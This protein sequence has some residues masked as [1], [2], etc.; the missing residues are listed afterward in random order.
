VHRALKSHLCRCTGWTP[1]LDAAQ[2]MAAG[3]PVDLAPLSSPR[4]QQ[5]AQ[6]EGR[7]AQTLGPEVALGGGGFA[8]DTAPRTAL[9][10]IAPEQLAQS[11]ELTQPRHWR[12][13]ADLTT[14][15]S[16][17]GSI[18]GRRSSLGLTWPIEHRDVSGRVLRELQTTWV[19]PAYL[20]PD[21]SWC[22]PGGEPAPTHANGGA[23]GGK[24]D[25]ALPDLV[26]ALSLEHDVPVRAQLT[27][28]Q[29]VQWGPKRPPMAIRVTLDDEIAKA[30]HS[31]AGY[32]VWI[33]VA[34]TAG[35][36]DAISALPLPDGVR[37]EIEEVDVLGPATS[38]AI[39]GSGWA[40]LAAVISSLRTAPQEDPNVAVTDVVLSPD[41]AR[42]EAWWDDQNHL[43]LRVDCG[44][45]PADPG[46]MLVLRSYC[47]GAIHMALGWVQSEGIAVDDEGQA[48]HLTLR[49]LGILT[50]AE[51][52]QVHLEVVDHGSQGPKAPPV[53]GSDAVFAVTAAA[54]WRRT[55]WA[56]RWPIQH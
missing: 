41:G 12:L 32:I 52:P 9:F 11:D 34:R 21:C 26:A 25:S 50:S 38:V 15:R 19:E 27:R 47:M 51:M 20:E 30:H 13:A 45:D 2:S 37:C 17:I 4:A 44:V 31:E 56:S 42:A 16:A 22:E 54:L 49:S 28:E 40:E 1:I 48:R 7:S 6:L 3:T 8:S 24:Q 53:N 46:E 14:W 18:P 36:V 23:F 5:R 43:H 33:R 10:A 39:R 35:I 29:V 55:Q